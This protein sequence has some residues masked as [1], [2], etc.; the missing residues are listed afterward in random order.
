MELLDSGNRI[1]QLLLGSEEG[2]AA[3]SGLLSL[4]LERLYFHHG[5]YEKRNG[6]SSQC[7][8]RDLHFFLRHLLSTCPACTS[9][10]LGWAARGANSQNGHDLCPHGACSLVKDDKVITQIELQPEREKCMIW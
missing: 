10:E 7:G 9:T 1:L 4:L 6:V 3:C 2:Q 8:M 5:L